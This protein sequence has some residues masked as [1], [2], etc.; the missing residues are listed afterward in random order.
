MTFATAPALGQPR[1]LT[2][3]TSDAICTAQLEV[4]MTTVAIKPLAGPH[5]VVICCKRLPCPDHPA[6]D[7]LR[8]PPL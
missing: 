8:L 2:S 4:A 3:Y 7:T 5:S 6:P 1:I